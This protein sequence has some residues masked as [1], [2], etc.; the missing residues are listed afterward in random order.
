MEK[1]KKMPKK[2]MQGIKLQKHDRREKFLKNK[3][4]SPS[5]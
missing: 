2:T 3:L 1:V 5:Q 4:G